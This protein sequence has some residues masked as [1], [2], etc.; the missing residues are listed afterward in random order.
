MGF[1]LVPPKP[2]FP[3]LL[4]PAPRA[5]PLPVPKRG[6]VKLLSVRNLV[7]EANALSDEETELDEAMM[8]IK[9]RGASWL[10]PLGRRHTVME[11]R[12]DQ[13]GGSS[14]GS[15]SPSDPGSD[16]NGSDGD[17]ASGGEDDEGEEQDLDAAMENLDGDGDEDEDGDEDGSGEEEDE[18]ED[19]E[20]G[21]VGSGYE[22]P[23]AGPAAR[24]Q[25]HGR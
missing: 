9:N 3:F 10:I 15:S 18:E 6:R 4:P 2:E 12:A 25:Y 7:A 13:Q 16:N 14:D 21:E 8:A 22:S 1:T 19:E 5:Y 20:P 11:E 24:F 23:D 17:D